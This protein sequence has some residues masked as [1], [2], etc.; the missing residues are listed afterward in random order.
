MEKEHKHSHKG[1]VPESGS[2]DVYYCPMHCE[3][4]K[5]Y[6]EP[7]SCPVCGMDLLKVP[8][9]R[10]KKTNEQYTC[11]M[12]PEIIRDEPGTC[13]ICGMNLVPM[14]PILE[15]E[16]YPEIKSLTRKLIVAIIFTFP[17]FSIAMLHMI[18]SFSLSHWISSYVLG[19][20]QLILSL[21]VVF[22]AGW[23]FYQR[24][25][26]SFVRRSLNMFSLIGVGT[27]AGFL[28]S[29]V[30][31]IFPDIF[32]ESIKTEEGLPPLY[33]ESVDVIL[34]LVLLGQ[35]LE[36]R[37]HRQTN[38]AIKKLIALA[39]TSAIKI[40]NGKDKSISIEEIM[41][42]DILR[43]RPGDKI[44]VDGVLKEG[45]AHVDESMISGEP[46]PVHKGEGDKL[47]G[48]TINSTT[49]FLMEA[50]KI[51]KETLLSQIIEMV[52]TASRSRAPI[53]KLVDRIS[54]YFV[55]I[56]IVIAVLT[57]IIWYWVGPEPK[58]A[59]S[60]V[61]AI[62][63]L[64][65][66]C[67][68]ALGLA[69]PMSVMVG[70][71]KGATNGVL[72]KNAE[73]LETLRK[74]DVLVI[75]KTGTITVGK[76]SVNSIISDQIEEDEML[77]IAASLNSSSE[78]P[79]GGAIVKKAEHKDLQ[80]KKVSKFETVPGKGIKGEI[81][82]EVFFVGNQSLF[83]EFGIQLPDSILIRSE[84]EQLK[85]QTISYVGNEKSVFGF[86]SLG[87]EIKQGSAKV[88][89]E[90]SS[91]GIKVMM[92]TGDNEKTA[93]AIARQVG[94]SEYKANCL[95]KDKL[96]IIDALQ[97]KGKIVA[98]AGDGIN[99]APALAI[100]NISFAMGTGTDVAIES[101]S[102]TLLGGDI[103]G[104]IRAIHLSDMVIRNIH[105]NLIFAFGYNVLG[106]PIAAGL[107]YPH[108]GILLSPM[109]AAA[110]MSFSSVT[111]IG[112]SLRLRWKPLN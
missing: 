65:I 24:A 4:E 28:F 57:F 20:V 70:I 3:G 68:C 31:L 102:I 110:A 112:N 98:M 59:H 107:L 15:E 54:A 21:P 62:A 32:P 51:G 66:A 25:W 39:P 22:Y 74:V 56:V 83:K 35:L 18:P 45:E 97:S 84:K 75:D 93:E 1:N 80:L 44:P 88:I 78:H 99:D 69:T 104:I 95:P 8:A 14:S 92:L 27:A 26:S 100:A 17:V 55:P 76:P 43:V 85:G 41:K 63:V 87:D 46:I 81:G 52:N 2:K 111:V 11:P 12:H 38:S 29:L 19:W 7:G 101:A 106:V 67:P 40:V 96:D 60:F 13:P 79:L 48:G 64:I 61:N 82:H 36:A 53:Q 72:V 94:I 73:S 30:A 89:Q 108:F 37:A 33:F 90:I 49:S 50:Q 6:E 47:I 10:S 58:L 109:I 91:R 23:M 77:R 5:V 71:G 9:A 42:G 105:Q 16:D 34:T 103:G 86:I